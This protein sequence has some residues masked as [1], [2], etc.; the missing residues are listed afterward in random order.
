VC[1]VIIL[2]FLAY[3]N[4]ALDLQLL[5]ALLKFTLK[6]YGTSPLRDLVR[7][8][9]LPSLTGDDDKAWDA[10][11][12]DYIKNTAGAVYHPLGTASMLPRED[13]GVVDP[14]LKVYGTANL[15]VVDAS[16]IPIVSF[17]QS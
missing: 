16:I 12:E 8:R 1:C 5:K 2:S 17:A 13:G 4:N 15:R 11:A 14:E 9:V 3:F 7:A 10:A 6:L